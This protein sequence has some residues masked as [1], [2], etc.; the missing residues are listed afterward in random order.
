[1]DKN[2]EDVLKSGSEDRPLNEGKNKDKASNPGL[3]NDSKKSC[4]RETVYAGGLPDSMEG[5]TNQE[6]VDKITEL[7]KEVFRLAINSDK[8]LGVMYLDS[9]SD[10]ERAIMLDRGNNAIRL[11]QTTMNMMSSETLPFSRKAVFF[12]QLLQTL[13]NVAR[14]DMRLAHYFQRGAKDFIDGKYS[15]MRRKANGWDEYD[16]PWPSEYLDNLAL[17]LLFEQG[18]EVVKNAVL[19]DMKVVHSTADGDVGFESFDPME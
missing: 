10:V 8:M 11:I 12:C 2:N 4:N 6:R 3:D 7:M 15:I 1:M 18:V 9:G 16:K 14:T 17:G 13:F 5:M 19:K